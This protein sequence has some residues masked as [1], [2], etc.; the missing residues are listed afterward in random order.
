MLNNEA[1]NSRWVARLIPIKHKGIQL[2][3]L[4]HIMANKIYLKGI[5]VLLFLQAIFLTAVSQETNLSGQFI[6]NGD[7]T[8]YREIPEKV[9]I[10]IIKPVGGRSYDSVTV[11][12]NK[13]KYQMNLEEPVILLFT[14]KGRSREGSALAPVRGGFDYISVL[15]LQC[16]IATTNCIIVIRTLLINLLQ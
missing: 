15:L 4:K 11:V 8:K 12:N 5:L 3:Q 6:L 10:S 14:V 16:L 2:W 7:L 1:C 13:F 9:I